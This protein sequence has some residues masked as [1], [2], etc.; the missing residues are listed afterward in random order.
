MCGRRRR[1]AGLAAKNVCTV[2]KAGQ[3]QTMS[4]GQ[5]GPGVIKMHEFR[6]VGGIEAERPVL[7]K[8]AVQRRAARAT[9]EPE[10]LPACS[11]PRQC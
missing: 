3:L 7:V 9:V 2:K 1:A 11:A 8:Q 10:H 6:R 4:T 5:L